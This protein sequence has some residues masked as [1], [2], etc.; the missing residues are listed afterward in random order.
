[1]L[2]WDTEDVAPRDREAYWVEA[3]CAAF[4]DMRARPR[5]RNDFRGRVSR[6]P[7][8]PL[9]VMQV[10]SVAQDVARTEAHLGAGDDAPF[11][12]ISQRS[13]PWAVAQAGRYT[14][15]RA[16]D[17]VLVDSAQPY[18]FHCPGQVDNVSIELPRGWLV[19]WLHQPQ[20]Q[21]ALRVDGEQGFG[22]GLRGLVD[23][24]RGPLAHGAQS[25]GAVDALG[26]LLQLAWPEPSPAA[27]VCTA[28]PRWRRACEALQARLAE[29]GLSAADLAA[30]A[31][32]SV[33]TLHRLWAA[34]GQSVAQALQAARV[35]RARRMLRDAAL[36]RLP[37][38]E[39]GRRCGFSDA[40]HFGRVFARHAGCTPQRWRHG[41]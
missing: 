21:V 20:A 36:A 5:E 2:T 31:G 34:H 14:E 29:P 15:L 10:D 4:L 13:R 9:A 26:H 12:L 8:G 16:G 19:Q 37:V 32:C 28:D 39:V 22:L 6:R 1:M 11:Y 40:S 24:L 35:D 18:R 7:L 23:G 41:G 33:A 17:L 30:D 3:I 27:P 25:A 38:A